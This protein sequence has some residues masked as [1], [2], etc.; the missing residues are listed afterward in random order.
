MKRQ[1]PPDPHVWLARQ[2]PDV[3]DR[4]AL[5]ASEMARETWGGRK[6]TPEAVRRGM[7]PLAIEEYW[8][9]EAG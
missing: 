5:R 9:M 4:I 1:K 7:I 6:E 2:P 8:Q 3:Q